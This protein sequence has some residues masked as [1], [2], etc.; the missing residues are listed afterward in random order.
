MFIGCIKLCFG[1]SHQEKECVSFNFINKLLILDNGAKLPNPHDK[2]AINEFITQI[3][4]TSKTILGGTIHFILYNPNVQFDKSTNS[5]QYVIH[6]CNT[7]SLLII[8]K[9]NFIFH[10]DQTQDKTFL[11]I[12]PSQNEMISTSQWNF[13]ESLFYNMMFRIK[14]I[15]QTN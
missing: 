12:I 9:L 5:I 1:S 6:M 13:I 15:Y 10:Y 4:T 11:N 7:K 3:N 8:H 2:N 14:K